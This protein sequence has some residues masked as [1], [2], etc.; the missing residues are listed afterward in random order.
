MSLNET[1]VRQILATIVDPNTGK[2]LVAGRSVRAVA[3][4][5]TAVRVDV[6]LGYPARSQVE[7][8]RARIA[9]ALRAAGAASAF[10]DVQWKIAAG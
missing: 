7:G 10:V 8:L 6:E 1:S 5:G 4:D 2:D 9:E 3:V